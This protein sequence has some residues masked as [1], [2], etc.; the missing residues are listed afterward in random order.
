MVRFR[1]HERISMGILLAGA[2]ARMAVGFLFN[3][4][5]EYSCRNMSIECLNS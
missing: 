1:G 3:G 4:K 2:E 5:K